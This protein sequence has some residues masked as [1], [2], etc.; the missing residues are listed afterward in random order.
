MNHRPEYPNHIDYGSQHMAD[1]PTSRPM[2]T[3]DI[4]KFV[5]A[6]HVC[7]P[8]PWDRQ[9]ARMGLGFQGFGFRSDGFGRRREGLRR[10]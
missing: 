6:Y 2:P 3:A 10:I 4:T 8:P 1:G 9:P 5:P 7:A